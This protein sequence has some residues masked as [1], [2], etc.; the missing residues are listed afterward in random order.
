MLQMEVVIKLKRVALIL[1]LLTL[2]LS[3]SLSSFNRN[4]SVNADSKVIT[5][6]KDGSGNFTN[7]QEAINSASDGA[8]IFVH[9]GTYIENVVVNKTVSLSG[10]NS[11]TTIIDGNNAG[12]VV[13]VTASGVS[14]SS[15]T[16]R[17]S[18]VNYSFGGIY[19]M[20]SFLTTIMNNMIQLTNGIRLSYSDN[21]LI[22]GNYLI[23]DYNFGIGFYHSNN[24]VIKNNNISFGQM[25]GMHFDSSSNNI[26]SGN[27][28][29]ENLYG[30]YFQ[31][32]SNNS[33]IYHNNFWSIRN[34]TVITQ[35]SMT[36]TWD[37]AGEGNFWSS[38][39]GHDLNDDGIGDTSHFIN[40]GIGAVYDMDRYPLMGPFSTFSIN[41]ESET[42][43]TFDIS[44]STISYF[45]FELGTETAN[46][47]IRFI[48]SGNAGTMGF[49]R[50]AIPTNL[51]SPPYIV[52]IDSEEILPKVLNVSDSAYVHLY[53]T[54]QH[55]N[56][57]ITI[58]YSEALHLYYELLES[59][60][61]LQSDF[62]TL[63]ST[64]YVLLHSYELIL[65]N[66]TQT[67]QE[68]ET[69]NTT[70]NVL[71]NNYNALIQSFAQL[72][73]NF[74][75]LE[76]SYHSL[77]GLNATYY[78]LLH[79]YDLLFGNYSLLQQSFADLNSSFADHLKDYSDQTQN[80]RNLLY[81]FA[82]TT[83]FFIITTVYLSKQAHTGK[84]GKI[85]KKEE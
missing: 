12:N 28:L 42:Y 43:D 48:V 47:M 69:L 10:E 18:G 79:N 68:V 49:S 63:N 50:I 54:Y 58:I 8:T 31:T 71:L 64:Y 84:N 21:N 25:Y 53:F 35:S 59:F 13:Y 3:L 7:I 85:R 76:G 66:L 40:K 9:N 52:L 24:N 81:I 4:I 15:F 11:D 6:A 39:D 5:V 82:I 30:M 45:R 46:K 2:H 73:K 55:R 65:G 16:I 51:M 26:I 32:D 80:M 56:Q 19:L 62:L 41:F 27:T 74:T 83:A 33:V 78:V 17:N 23:L 75:V 20:N 70:Y 37:Y 1:L 60:T 44:N 67:Q 72:Q 22:T 29:Q 61:A 14:I 57:T 36:N 34:D 77:Q 38:Y